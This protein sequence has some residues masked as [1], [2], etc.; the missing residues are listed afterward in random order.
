MLLEFTKYHGAGNDFILV[1]DRREVFPAHKQKLVQLLC[2]R[3]FGI[4]ADGLIL[5]RPAPADSPAGAIQPLFS[6]VYFNADG[7][8]GSLCGNGGRCVVH[9]AS[10]LGVAAGALG[11]TVHF[12]ASDGLHEAEFLAD[13]R[14]ALAM[15]PV[16]K[17]QEHPDPNRFPTWILDTGSPHFVQFRQD[18]AAL[19]V[20]ELGRAIRQSALFVQEG[21]NVNF[22]A[23]GEGTSTDPI[24]MRTYERGVEAETLACGT[25]ATAVALANSLWKGSGGAQ[26]VFLQ[27]PGGLL[28][29]QFVRNEDGFE[30]IRLIGP[31]QA[32][33]RGTWFGDA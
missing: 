24:H 26:Q 32:V 17:W 25:G 11:S 15:K 5:L 14:I 18:S 2:N 3:H 4:G 12:A 10:V 9:F 20:E 22:A 16:K 29:V 7:R 23:K 28:E 30:Q 33:F 21:I 19:D 8:E 1:D 6:M 13:E 31:A 27:A